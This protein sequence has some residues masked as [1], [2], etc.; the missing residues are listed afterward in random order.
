MRKVKSNYPINHQIKKLKK[1]II[2]NNKI[3]IKYKN[4]ANK[5]LKMKN[6][7]KRKDCR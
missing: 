2:K 3:Q 1:I 5:Y 7:K 4:K 6:F